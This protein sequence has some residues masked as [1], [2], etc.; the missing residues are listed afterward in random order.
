MLLLPRAAIVGW[1]RLTRERVGVLYAAV[2]SSQ[3]RFIHS[4]AWKVLGCVVKLQ[5]AEEIH[6]K[7]FC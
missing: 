1:P 5:L 3:V 4:E 6:L 7:S 2:P